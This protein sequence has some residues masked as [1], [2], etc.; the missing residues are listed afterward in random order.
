M[1]QILIFLKNSDYKMDSQTT[2]NYFCEEHLNEEGIAFYADALNADTLDNLPEV[3]L[4]HVESCNKCKKKIIFINQ[5]ISRDKI[6]N[7]D[8]NHQFPDA[9]PK[10]R[11]LPLQKLIRIAATIIFTVGVGASA[12][13]YL[14]IKNN[15][16][17]KNNEVV[18][19]RDTSY[20]KSLVKKNKVDQRKPGIIVAEI[21]KNTKSVKVKNDKFALTM[22]ES[23]LFENLIASSPRSQEVKIIA[24]F[25]NQHYAE[26][27]TIYFE[28][29][30]PP[31]T[32]LTIK[33][34]NNKGDKVFEE[35]N[36]TI[37]KCKISK[38]LSPG[39]Y[40]WKLEKSDDLMYVGKFIVE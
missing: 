30:K 12:Y 36:M 1:Y 14:G 9:T 23:K 34:Y 28:L 2:V 39:L 21:D 10:K 33:I 6:A 31:T 18:L 26:N 7:E 25:I 11:R 32:S 27:D 17:I 24:P 19:N 29:K 22:L 38:K 3:L 13:Y 8:F 35:E 5:I 37:V 4:L 16:N 20:K 15:S 40:Y